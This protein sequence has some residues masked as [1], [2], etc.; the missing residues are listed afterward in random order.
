MNIR[1][2]IIAGHY[3]RDELGRALVPSEGGSQ[4]TVCATDAPHPHPIV[5]FGQGYVSTWTADGRW[6]GM[7][8]S[9]FNN[10]IS[11]ADL[12]PPPPRKREGWIVLERTPAG[13]FVKIAKVFAT[14]A[15]AEA[16]PFISSFHIAASVSYDEEWPT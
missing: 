11:G 7:V 15:D 4:I 16:I 8:P 9:D 6:S 10:G 1:D 14:K 12:L 5:G 2:H 3:P 13:A